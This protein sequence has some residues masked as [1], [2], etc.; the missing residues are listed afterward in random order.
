LCI[1]SGKGIE[2][3]WLVAEGEFIAS[4]ERFF[5]QQPA[6]ENIQALEDCVFWLSIWVCL[7]LLFQRTAKKHQNRKIV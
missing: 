6:F 7:V 3:T 4:A 2:T 5:E 1:E